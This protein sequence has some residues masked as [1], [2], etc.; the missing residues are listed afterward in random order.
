MLSET[1]DELS[2]WFDID[3][4]AWEKRL[5]R[6]DEKSRKKPQKEHTTSQIGTPG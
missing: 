4:G 1:Q 2:D 6:I 3:E 5:Q